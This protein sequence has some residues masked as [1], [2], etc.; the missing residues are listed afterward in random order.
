MLEA[1]VVAGTLKVR[2]NV[3]SLAPE[4]TAAVSAP[5]CAAAAACRPNRT[6][7]RM[8]RT[9]TI[10]NKCEKAV[11]RAPTATGFT[12]FRQPVFILSSFLF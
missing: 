10:K 7:S 2:S 1:N 9:K 4:F 3:E 12:L 11:F 5:T 6:R 8:P